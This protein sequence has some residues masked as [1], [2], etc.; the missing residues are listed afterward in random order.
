MED[1]VDVDDTVTGQGP[2]IKLPHARAKFVGKL[3]LNANPDW[4]AQLVHA[5]EPIGDRALL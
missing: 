3:V 5:R 2:R 4:H 1:P